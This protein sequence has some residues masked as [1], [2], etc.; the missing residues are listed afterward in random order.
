VCALRLVQE[1]PGDEA[2]SQTEH[3][4]AV[5]WEPTK[6]ALRPLRLIV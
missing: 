5:T 3:A 2:L 1:S 6:P 4:Q